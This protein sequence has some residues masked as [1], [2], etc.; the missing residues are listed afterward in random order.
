MAEITTGA[1]DALQAT[2]GVYLDELSD[3]AIDV[4]LEHQ[5]KKM[6]PLSFVPIF[7]LGGAYQRADTDATAFGG[8]RTIRYVI[9]ISATALSPAEY[10]AERAW[11]RAYWSA[12]AEH[13]VGVGGYV[14][15]MSE[16]EEDRVRNAYGPKYARLQRIKAAYDPNNVF[17]LNANIP[18][19]G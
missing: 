2:I 4:I 17:H 3:G 8:S 16:Y 1:L 18:P 11:S 5:A 12:L 10:E 7:T 14:N 15:F 19:K 9:N 13:A 6:S